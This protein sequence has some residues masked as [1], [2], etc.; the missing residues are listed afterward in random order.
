MKHT[1][2]IRTLRKPFL[3]RVLNSASCRII[4]RIIRVIRISR[5]YFRLIGTSYGN[6]VRNFREL[7]YL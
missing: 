1:R 7:L 5:E 3:S 6:I 4:F 2:L